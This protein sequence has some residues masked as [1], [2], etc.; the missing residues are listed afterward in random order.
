MVEYS[1]TTLEAEDMAKITSLFSSK[2]AKTNTDG[3]EEFFKE[4]FPPVVNR[5]T[6]KKEEE[7]SHLGDLNRMCNY[8][9]L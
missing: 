4:D 2:K 6:T 5:P 1:K 7:N 8:F 9:S 3:Q